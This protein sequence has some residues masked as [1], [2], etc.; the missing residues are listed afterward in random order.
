M[1]NIN[2]S[3][4]FDFSKTTCHKHLELASD[5][6][7]YTIFYLCLIEYKTNLLQETS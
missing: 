5:N 6:V 7:Q 2:V 3:L 4:F 1:L